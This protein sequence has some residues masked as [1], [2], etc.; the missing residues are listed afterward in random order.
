MK[1]NFASIILIWV[2]ITAC[3]LVGFGK[4]T[5][6]L[7]EKELQLQVGE[8]LN[9]ILASNVTALESW[10]QEKKR[11][12][13]SLVN[14]PEN[15][16]KIRSLLIQGHDA[17]HDK[18]QLQE[19]K[20][21]QWLK[22][23]LFSEAK[24]Y[25]FTGY[26][27][28]DIHG[29]IIVTNSDTPVENFR[30]PREWLKKS[31]RGLTSIT[32]PFK[33]SIPIKDSN[34]VFRDDWPTML[35]STPIYDMGGS[36]V[37]IMAFRIR[38]E[39]EFS[40]IINIAKLGLTGKT[41]AIDRNGT[42]LSE[43]RHLRGMEDSEVRMT[44][45]I[46]QIQLK[47]GNT[48]NSG[49]GS[50]KNR[51][52]LPQMAPNL[53]RGESGVNVFG[54]SDFRGTP[55]VGAWTW[56]KELDLGLA[57]E[58][59]FSEAFKAIKILKS[60]L[61][62]IFGLMVMVSG[63]G[64]ILYVYKR[65]YQAYLTAAKETAEE[66]SQFK[67]KFLSRMSHDLC[68]PMNAIVGFTQ[69]LES[70]PDDPLNESQALAVEQISKAGE[71]LMELVTEI[72][73]L[74]R[75]ESGS[76]TLNLEPC[77]VVGVIGDVLLKAQP[78]ADENRIELV[79]KTESLDDCLVNADRGA[80]K[81]VLY[82]LVSNAILY[83]KQDGKVFLE[84]QKPG[85]DLLNITVKDTGP[86]IPKDQYRAIFRPFERLGVEDSDIKGSGIGLTL[87][88]NLLEQMG[89]SLN[90][91]STLGEGSCFSIQFPI[92]KPEEIAND[93]VIVVADEPLKLEAE[94]PE[95]EP[96]HESP[97]APE[98]EK[99]Q[100]TKSMLNR[101]PSRV[102]L[103]IE[104][105]E[106]NLVVVQQMLK[107]RPNFELLHSFSVDPGIELARKH[108][109]DLILMDLNLPK[110]DGVAAFKELQTYPETRDI[111]VIAFSAV[112]LEDRVNEVLD[113]GFHDYITKPVQ[114]DYFLEVLDKVLNVQTL[115][116]NEI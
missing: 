48:G 72:L 38:P 52:A 56:V 113:L 43:T 6:N 4:F 65:N 28:F 90:I 98:A 34:G 21:A 16:Q 2:I 106:T 87:V 5:Y 30:F 31:M 19:Y 49:N 1:R 3:L 9:S 15:L 80:L 57:T 82:N 116:I 84:Y 8:S 23:N 74:S 64:I 59:E 41:Y 78:L 62:M 85:Q 108:L 89:G 10:A 60:V 58:M 97:P 66:E 36:L 99:I 94:A 53:A 76:Q 61:G 114:I 101:P 42:L 105:N 20:D 112:A 83:N 40:Q 7:V 25:G 47:S 93:E 46:F 67:T 14:R 110:K 35:A 88:K 102:I 27:L 24:N 13:I 17:N 107:R 69:L 63:I 29:N 37:G 39:T 103:Y 44:T 50:I 71:H 86:G 96:S 109:P 18:F 92:L 45:E 95:I 54:Y 33:S 75:I 70:D 79:D 51:G 104:D 115:T 81:Q 91:S 11:N 73:D 111:P 77:D 100:Q 12:T 32:L 26:L 22:L 68:S 55:V